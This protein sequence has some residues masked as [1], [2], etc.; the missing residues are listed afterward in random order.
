MSPEKELHAEVEIGRLIQRYA[1]AADAYAQDAFAD[2]F[3]EDGVFT[4]AD[5]AHRGRA[6]IARALVD[7]GAVARRHFFT[8]PAIDFRSSQQATGRG[9]CLYLSYDRQTGEQKAPMAVDYEDEYELTAAGW[10]IA[11]RSVKPSFR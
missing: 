7:P 6:A 8:Q 11:S 2:C 5:G 1:R 9:Y 10:L 4:R 3:T